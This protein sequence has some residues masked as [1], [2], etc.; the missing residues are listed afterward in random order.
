MYAAHFAAINYE[1]PSV[2]LMQLPAWKWAALVEHWLWV[3]TDE[4]QHPALQ[5]ELDRPIQWTWIGDGTNTLEMIGTAPPARWQENKAGE[6][7]LSRHRKKREG[8]TTSG[9]SG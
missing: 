4:E 8:V 3:H 2:E 7:L 6:V 1:F 5:A 9:E